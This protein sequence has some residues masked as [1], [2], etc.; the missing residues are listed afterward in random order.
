MIGVASEMIP[1]VWPDYSDMIQEA[2]EYGNGEYEIEDLFE[3]V[4][5]GAMQLWATPK[6]VAI[7][8]VI[9]YPR[10]TTCLI[11]AAGGDL[12][13]LRKHLPL[14]EEWAAWLGCDAVEV[15]GRKGWRR[16]LPDYTQCQI[17]LRKVLPCIAS[18]EVH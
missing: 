10:K 9:K 15:M 4:C 1:K 2:L 16:A 13:D 3:A 8:T 11:V 6:S 12:D 17:H 7:T 5:C 14:V 18:S